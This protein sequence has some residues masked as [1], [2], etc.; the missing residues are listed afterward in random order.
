MSVPEITVLTR[1]KS[2]IREICARLVRVEIP[3]LTER[4]I[5]MDHGAGGMFVFL[6]ER[7]RGV[8]EVLIHIQLPLVRILITFSTSNW[9]LIPKEYLGN[10]L[11]DI[12]AGGLLQFCG[13]V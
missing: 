12:S 5:W 3:V 13:T 4:D 2:L 9:R 1:F 8:E 7:L 11:Q 6:K 10:T